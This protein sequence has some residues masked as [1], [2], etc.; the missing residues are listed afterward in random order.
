MNTRFANIIL[1]SVMLLVFGACKDVTSK[2]HGPIVLGDSSTIVTEKDPQKLQDL[3]TELHPNIPPSENT[4]TVATKKDTV[5]QAHID[6]VKKTNTLPPAN[7]PAETAETATAGLRADFKVTSVQLGNVTAK[8]SGKPNLERASGA[9]YTL[10]SGNINGSILKVTGNVTKVSQ[11]YQ[12]VVILRNG[13]A[14]F[15]VEALSNTTNWQPLKGGNNMYRITGLDPASLEYADDGPAAI[16]NAVARAAQRHRMS[17]KKIQELEASMHNVKAANQ[18]PLYVVL[19]SVMW[20]IDGKDEKGR[21]F[22]KQVRID[23]PM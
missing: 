13:A 3:V 8:L 4:D 10:V 21:A 7:Q 15:P 23:V 5:A 12:S 17:R 22:S 11:R 20:K 9:V 16:R 2:N 14:E 18:K 6:T 1:V 19:R